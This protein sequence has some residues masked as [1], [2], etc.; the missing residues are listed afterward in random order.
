MSWIR[1]TGSKSLRLIS[2]CLR[3]K[4]RKNNKKDLSLSK[5]PNDMQ[6]CLANEP[7]PSKQLMPEMPAC[8]ADGPSLSKQLMQEMPACLA[9]V[10]SLSKQLM[11]CLAEGGRSFCEQLMQDLPAC[12]ME[13]PSQ[14]TNETGESKCCGWPVPASISNFAT[15]ARN[16]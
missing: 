2:Y 4:K 6:T 5:E 11:H 3:P 15:M 13:G 12:L 1:N 8:L 7:S 9:E 14:L 10:P 16:H